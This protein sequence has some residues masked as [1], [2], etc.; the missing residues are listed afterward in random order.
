M[1]NLKK[2]AF[3]IWLLFITTVYI[4]TAVEWL[5]NPFNKRASRH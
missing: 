2:Y 5:K 4:Y 3:L 1:I